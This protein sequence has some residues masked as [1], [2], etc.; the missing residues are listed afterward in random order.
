MKKFDYPIPYMKHLITEE[1]KEYVVKAL[2]SDFITQG[3]F[4]EL[5]EKEMAKL[6]SKN[7][8]VM[9]ANGTAALHLVAEMLNQNIKKNN[10][11]IVTTF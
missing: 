10:K 2:E 8:S 6:T 7:F 9:C 11:N 3:P 4:V 1:D 5:V